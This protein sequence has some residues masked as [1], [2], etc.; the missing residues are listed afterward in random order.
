MEIFD[1]LCP[2][3]HL[4]T[5]DVR[6]NKSFMTCVQASEQS[7]LYF[8]RL[9]ERYFAKQRR[10]R[11]SKLKKSLDEI[12]VTINVIKTQIKEASKMNI[13]P[14]IGIDRLARTCVQKQELLTRIG[15]SLVAL[16]TK[17]SSG[18]L[19][20]NIRHRIKQQKQLQKR[21]M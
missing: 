8:I 21:P 6:N 5:D 7:L 20:N 9:K 13:D 17:V 11:N 3:V 18:D 4:L 1:V 14:S 10:E 16:K 15:Q 2:G 19:L 12:E